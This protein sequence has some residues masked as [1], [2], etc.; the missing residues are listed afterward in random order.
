MARVSKA[1]DV[2]RDELLDTALRLCAAVGY[3]ALSIDQLTREASVAKGTFYYYFSSKQGMLTALVDRFV[4]DLFADLE[5]KASIIEGTGQQRFQQLMIEATSWKT[6]RISDALLFIPLLYKPA[7][8]E[9]RHRLFESWTR[10]IRA[11]FLPHI[12]LGAQ[13]GSLTLPEGADPEATTDLVMSLWVD[14]SAR[15]FDRALAAGSA[16]EFATILSRGV[17]ALTVAVERVLGAA[18]GSFAVPYE[19]ALLLTMHS[20]FIAALGGGADSNS[21]STR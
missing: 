2:R 9:L 7:N 11:L 19:E 10:R 20:P 14:G 12:A 17:R 3:E 4:G 15:F 8:L 1:P 18:P 13:D 16:E 21:R 6:A 5:Q